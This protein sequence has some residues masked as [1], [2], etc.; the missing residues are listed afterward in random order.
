M[1]SLKYEYHDRYHND[2][3]NH[4]YWDGKVLRYFGDNITNNCESDQNQNVTWNY[5]TREI[6]IRYSS[7]RIIVADENGRFKRNLFLSSIKYMNHRECFV[8][9]KM[10]VMFIPHYIDDCI[11]MYRC[12]DG[13][14]ISTLHF[15]RNLPFTI[16]FHTHMNE[17]LNTL[18]VKANDIITA[19]DFNV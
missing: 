7:Y 12:S 17:S 2:Y 16:G 4:G 6:Y 15:P 3:D 10:N 8:Y 14:H 19:Y 1:L 18:F 5:I 13:S 9:S 11:S